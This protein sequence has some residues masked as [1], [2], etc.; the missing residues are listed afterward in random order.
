MS[1]VTLFT[2]MVMAEPEARFV[3][4]FFVRQWIPWALIVAGSEV[5]AVHW[6]VSA[7]AGAALNKNPRA[8]T[9]KSV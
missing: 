8:R 1:M 6:V 2:V 5:M 4:R 9:P 3:A 7:R